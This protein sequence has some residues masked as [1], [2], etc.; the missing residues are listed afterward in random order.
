[1][2]YRKLGKTNIKASI[3]GFGALR[4]PQLD[5]NPTHID[6]KKTEEMV[7]YAVD[8]GINMFDTALVYHT[9]DRTKPGVSEAIMGDILSRGFY[10]KVHVSTKMASWNIDSWEYF[11][12]TLDLELER[13]HKDQI[14]LFFIH[15]FRDSYY[16]EMKEMGIYE[17]LDRALADGRIKHACFSTHGSLE[18]LDEI[19]EDYDKWSAALTQ[20]NYLDEEDT[21]GLEGVRKLHDL[22]IGTMIM[23]PLRG[24]KLAQ[25]QPPTVQKIFN[26]AESNY[27]PIEWAFY[28]L[29]DKEEVNCV[30]SG[31]SNMVQLEENIAIA[32]NYDG[33]KLNES[34]AQVLKDVKQEYD[35]LCQ[36][37]CTGCNYCMPCPFGV[38]IPKC[39][40]EYNMDLLGDPDVVGVQYQ[41]HL[42]ADR[43]AH[44]CVECKKCLDACPQSINI[45][46]E[47]KVVDNHFHPK[48]E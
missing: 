8:H 7:E 36:I 20:L 38:N 24:G 21:T 25:K 44:N 47:L 46:Q 34:D 27:S 32:D 13:L 10:D 12:K 14:E 26:K 15:S 39:F 19:L 9:T 33:K 6:V 35:N 2:K 37:P 5:E 31:M 29:W 40:L 18:L 16:E 30:L 43:Q 3:L 1:M 17:F 41:Y 11:D 48:K 42:N 23:E 4:L 45:P 22:G 28:Y